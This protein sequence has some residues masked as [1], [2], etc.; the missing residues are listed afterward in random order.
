MAGEQ[1]PGVLGVQFRRTPDFG[2][3]SPVRSP[4][5]GTGGT[6][7]GGTADLETA[8]AQL[9]VETTAF[10]WRFIADSKAR[11]SYIAQS[12]AAAAHY[13]R[14]VGSGV[15]SPRQAAQEVNLLRNEIMTAI[16]R[17]TS[18][19]GRA[20]AERKKS[21]GKTLTELQEIYAQRLF[22]RPFDGLPDERRNR[23]WLE[24]VD[25][26]GRP[27]EGATRTAR[28][29]G[30]VGRRLAFLSTAFAVYN[31]ATAPD[32]PRQAAKEAGTSGAGILGGIAGGAAAGLACGPGAPVCVAVGVFVG[33]AAAALG[34][35][36]AFDAWW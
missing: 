36:F 6:D 18:D 33:G 29:L 2:T 30:H 22:G 27:Q 17:I 3:L 5:P 16:R 11:L 28:A 26:A 23:V 12:E 1:L 10:A 4:T 13:R 9:K 14:Q 24:I 32:K 31:I 15:L 25:A 19:T 35:E 21:R 34:F 7:P 20:W 8:I